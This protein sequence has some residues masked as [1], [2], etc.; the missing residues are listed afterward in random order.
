M[1]LEGC[2]GG[3]A[4]GLGPACRLGPDQARALIR[5][6]Q[7]GEGAAGQEIFVG[8]IAMI[9][10]QP[11]RG[12]HPALAVGPADGVYAGG[13]S[14]RRTPPFRP[15]HQRRN[16][17]RA[18][19]QG[20]GRLAG[21][22]LDTGDGGRRPHLN[23]RR[24][25]RLSEGDADAAVLDHI[26]QRLAARAA[27][28]LVGVEPQEGRRGRPAGRAR[29]TAVGHQDM[30]HPA[31]VGP[32]GLAQAQGVQH[33]EGRKG[34]GRRT[35]V[36]RRRKLC[37]ERLR[38]DQDHLQ[39]GLGRRQGERRPAQPRTGDDDVVAFGVCHG[40][41]VAPEDRNVQTGNRR[42]ADRP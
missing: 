4:Q 2:V 14:N 26:A 33:A 38:I 3:V 29:P 13:P 18:V 40:R 9:A 19:R 24:R 34:H 12:H 36:E 11:H 5:Q 15:H 17:G 21:V 10:A 8:D 20:H 37:A 1:G 42:N 41:L 6:R 35:A 28:D 31:G 23:P 30:V 32:Q 16:Q 7:D 27:A 39:P 25:H 22:G